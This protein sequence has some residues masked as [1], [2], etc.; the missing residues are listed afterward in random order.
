MENN[1][2]NKGPQQK[3]KIVDTS[4][5]LSGLCIF[6]IFDKNVM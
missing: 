1:P 6:Q 5:V 4:F 3:Y 2:K